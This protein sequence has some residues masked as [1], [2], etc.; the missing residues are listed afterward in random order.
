MGSKED[1]INQIIFLLSKKS[2]YITGQNIVIDGGYT[3]V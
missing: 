1:V 3:S 2:D